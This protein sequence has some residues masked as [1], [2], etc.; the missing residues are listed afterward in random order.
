MH[1]GRE[2]SRESFVRAG[3]ITAVT[4]NVFGVTSIFHTKP[5]VNERARAFGSH[6][7]KDWRRRGDQIVVL[8]EM[9]GPFEGVPGNGVFPSHAAVRARRSFI[10]EHSGLAILSSLPISGQKFRRFDDT[11][12]VQMLADVGVQKVSVRHPVGSV[13]VY[14]THL[15][16]SLDPK[17]PGRYSEIRLAQERRTLW[18]MFSQALREADDEVAL[19]GGDWNAHP[20]VLPV[21]DPEPAQPGMWT[22]L[23]KSLFG[24]G[25]TVD[26]LTSVEPTPEYKALVDEMGLT[27]LVTVIAKFR[28]HDPSTVSSFGACVDLSEEGYRDYPTNM[29]F[30]RWHLMAGREDLE[31]HVILDRC[32]VEFEDTGL[33]D[34]KAVRIRAYIEIHRRSKEAMKENRPQV[35]Y[36]YPGGGE[37]VHFSARVLADPS[38]IP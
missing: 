7:I 26:Q 8:Q 20:R 32:D 9:F 30:D 6:V 31:I 2:T 17:N 23:R 25:R 11:C 1:I 38:F 19:V 13:G 34:H 12:P 15:A 21:V 37:R 3:E 16:P 18:E 33:S 35:L 29:L 4:S 22:R 36:V 24:P 27:D 14:N 28:G 10:P 5:R